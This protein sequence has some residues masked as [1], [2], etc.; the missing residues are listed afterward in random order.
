MNQSSEAQLIFKDPFR[1]GGVRA[2]ELP[3]KS[4]VR[5]EWRE[6]SLPL[7]H[8]TRPWEA[9]IRSYPER[10]GDS[11]L[12]VA[13]F[14]PSMKPAIVR[15]GSNQQVSFVRVFHNEEGTR[16]EALFSYPQ[17]TQKPEA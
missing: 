7:S 6:S 15:I 4:G 3:L 9:W 17:D 16:R 11:Q 2:Y 5:L 13:K 10:P 8:K 1:S 12:R 14:E